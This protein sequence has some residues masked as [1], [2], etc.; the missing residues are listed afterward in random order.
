M[1]LIPNRAWVAK[2][3]RLE[4][5]GSGVSLYEDSPSPTLTQNMSPT[6]NCLQMKT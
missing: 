4:R 6:G 5:Q 3:L 1:E 2:N